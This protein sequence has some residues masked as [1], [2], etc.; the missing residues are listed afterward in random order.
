MNWTLK[1]LNVSN[2]RWKINLFLKFYSYICSMYY[3]M[4]IVLL[5]IRW[6]V[7]HNYTYNIRKC[8][9]TFRPFMLQ[10]VG[11]YIQGRFLMKEWV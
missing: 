9:K 3:M 2:N 11:L 8:L 1:I 6:K 10:T 7:V 4:Q 5:N